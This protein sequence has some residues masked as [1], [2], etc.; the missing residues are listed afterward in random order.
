MHDLVSALF[1]HFSL[2]RFQDARTV[3]LIVSDYDVVV[4]EVCEELVSFSGKGSV[5][6]YD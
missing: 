1:L 2:C 6:F 5:D 3:E 4:T